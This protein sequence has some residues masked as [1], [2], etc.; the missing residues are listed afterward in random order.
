[1]VMAA[2]GLVPYC[3]KPEQ[4]G[5]QAYSTIN[6]RSNRV[7]KWIAS[8]RYYRSQKPS[9]GVAELILSSYGPW[10]SSPAAVV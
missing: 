1:M 7:Q 2:W 6:A 3:L 10:T 8:W 9:G 4:L 5:K